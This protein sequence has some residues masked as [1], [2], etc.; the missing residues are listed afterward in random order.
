MVIVLLEVTWVSTTVPVWFATGAPTS[1]KE[2]V[3]PLMVAFS[4][5]GAEVTE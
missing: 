1:E 5:E 4:H 2:S 3:L